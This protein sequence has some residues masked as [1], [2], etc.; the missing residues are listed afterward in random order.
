MIIT[1]GSVDISFFSNIF[2]KALP[3]VLLGF[4]LCMPFSI[5]AQED[6]ARIYHLE[7]TSFAL[8]VRGERIIMNTESV[9]AGGVNLERAGIVHTGASTFLEI[10]LIPSGTVIK[11]SENTSLV[12]NG[13]DTTGG[14]VDL[15]LLYGRI[16]VVTGN[17]MGAGPV[18]IRSGGISSRTETGDLGADYVLEPGDRN[19][20]PRPLF[21]VHTFRGGAEVFPYGRGGPQPYLGGS[22][23]LFANEGESL[24]LDI[25]SSYT[26]VEKK[27]LGEETL[28]YW[29]LFNFAG[30]SPIP[31][32]ATAIVK[33]R[34]EPVVSAP[35]ISAPV[36]Q[37]PVDAGPIVVDAAPPPPPQPVQVE[38]PGPIVVPFE[39][40]EF[41]P[42]LPTVSSSRTKNLCMILGLALTFT[43]AAVQ[44]VTYNMY[45]INRDR[46]ANTIFTAA[47][48]PLGV[49]I[50]TT[51]GGF[52]YNPS[53]GRK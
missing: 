18:V 50:I 33:A 37:A 15:G 9:R 7:G 20:I 14:F 4:A 6:G 32:P 48:I 17:G 22:Q 42:R 35:V 39:Y 2:K 40:E 8:T 41:S 49:G 16:R 5:A 1:C 51:L 38:V 52:L 28:N 53:P 21:R 12:Y 10:Q 13:I 47:Q 23:T 26:F 44:G 27:P 11:M 30:I 36:I 24:T 19:S 31:M 3:A 29:M 25:S 45:D 43:G 34:Q 46:I